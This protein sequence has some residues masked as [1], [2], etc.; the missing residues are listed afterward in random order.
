MNHIHCRPVRP[1]RV[2]RGFTLIEILVVV[3]IIAL[4]AAIL[5]PVFAKAREN[6]RRSAC[7][8]NLKQIGLGFLQYSQDY[9]ERYPVCGAGAALDVSNNIG[10][11]PGWAG[12]IYPYLKSSQIFRCPSDGYRESAPVAPR[13]QVSYAYNRNIGHFYVGTG[14]T[15]NQFVNGSLIKLT[16]P[17]RTV[18]SIEVGGSVLPPNPNSLVDN[19]L[20][21][22]LDEGGTSETDHSP[23]SHGRIVYTTA[24]GGSG[25][26][27]FATGTM[28]NR[29]VGTGS[30]Q[31]QFTRGYPDG[32]H[33][34][35]A[36]VLLAD[37]HVK[38][39]KGDSV[40][41]GFTPN[42]PTCTQDST[43]TGCSGANF[44]AGTQALG[45]FAVT[46]SVY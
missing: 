20:V 3:A 1:R 26:A 34:E 41:T 38:W 37:G 23:S 35:G 7:Q 2:F 10:F 8:S 45:S 39:Y 11:G 18:M 32:R 12:Q 44:A 31:T 25:G 6:A 4:L 30:M 29:G 22:A 14:A 42:L 46:F 28:G 27:A 17:T 24:A 13:V 19:V 40:S 43:A 16:E 5:F 9:D 33:L 15:V 36:N 21:T